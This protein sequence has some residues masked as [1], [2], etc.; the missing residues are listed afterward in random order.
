MIHFEVLKY[1][2]AELASLAPEMAAALLHP[3]DHETCIDHPDYCHAA[4]ECKL[5]SDVVD[6]LRA[7]GA[8]DE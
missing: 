5:A 1:A 4:G 2:D 8:N 7:I 6:K 3:R